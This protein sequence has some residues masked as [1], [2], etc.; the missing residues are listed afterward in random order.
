[1]I[2]WAGAGRVAGIGFGA[3]FLVLVV[4]ALAIL[5]VGAV[6]QRLGPEAR[7]KKAN[8]GKDGNPKR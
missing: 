3:V 2:D 6:L 7:T 4:L 5:A 1:M 8:S